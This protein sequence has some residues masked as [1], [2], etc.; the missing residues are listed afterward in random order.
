MRH[1]YLSLIRKDHPD[2]LEILTAKLADAKK[3]KWKS[4]VKR[5]RKLI[6]K[7]KAALA[8]EQEAADG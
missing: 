7:H 6:A 5:L 1:A 4:E 2:V 3:W 8:A